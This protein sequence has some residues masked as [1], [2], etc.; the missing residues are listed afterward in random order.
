[1]VAGNQSIAY[2]SG[3]ADGKEVKACVLRTDGTNCHKETRHS[4]E[5]AGAQTDIVYLGSLRAGSAGH[6]YALGRDVSLQDYDILAFPGGFSYGDYISAG[7]IFAQDLKRLRGEV[8]TFVDA[9]KPIIG[10]CN[11]FQ[12][13]VKSG[14][15]PDYNFG[16]RQTASLAYNSHLDFECRWVHLERPGGL[17]KPNR[18]IWT[19]GV[20]SIDLPVA[21]GEGRFVAPQEIL[22]RLIEE[23]RIVFQYAYGLDPTMDFPG[24]PNGSTHSIAGVCNRTGLIFG[25]MPHPERYWKPINHPEA[26]SQK[27]KG[28][29]PDEGAGVQIFRNAVEYVRKQKILAET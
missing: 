6:D 26:G 16:N 21:H 20:E 7:T 18:C 23:D 2:R 11:G 13:L 5:L 22:E 9:K 25:L 4:F 24:N 29:L 15:L 27:A 3:A 14:M 10:I 19:K 17:R 12:A 1:M 8:E 28:T